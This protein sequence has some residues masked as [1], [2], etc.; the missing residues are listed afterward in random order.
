MQCGLRKSLLATNSPSVEI[1]LSAN[2]F[3]ERGDYRREVAHSERDAVLPCSKAA[4]KVNEMK[5]TKL[6]LGFS[7]LC[8]TASMSFTQTIITVAGNGAAGYSGDGGLATV[9]KLFGPTGVAVDLAGNIYIADFTNNCVRKVSIGTRF[10]TTFAGM[11][12]SM[13]AYGGDTLPAT[14]ANLNQPFNLALDFSG[15]NL[16]IT[17]PGNH[18]VRKVNLNTNIISTAAGT[19]SMCA[20]VSACGDGGKATLAQLDAPHGLAVDKADNLYIGDQGNHCIRKVNTSGVISTIAGDRYHYIGVTGNVNEGDGGQAHSSFLGSPD[21]LALDG[22]G[23]LYIADNGDQVIRKITVCSNQVDGTC[24]ISRI[25][26]SYGI[27]GFSG[28]GGPATSAKLNIPSG[29][30]MDF[31][32]NKLYVSD[33]DNRRVRVIDGGGVIDAFAG[34]GLPGYTGDNGPATLARL[35]DTW[36]LAVDGCGNV[37]IADS[38]ANVIRKVLKGAAPTL[39]PSITTAAPLCSGSNISATGHYAGSTT[40]DSYSWQLQSCTPS[41]I[42]TSAY[43]SGVLTYSGVPST[44]PFVFPNTATVSCNQNYLITFTVK[45]DCPVPTVAKVTKQILINCKPTPIITGNTT[46]CF[47]KPTTLCANYPNN[48][49]YTVEWIYHVGTIVTDVDAQCITVSPKANTIYNLS[50][51]DN[52]TG[53]KSSISVP[54]T[55]VKSNPDFTYQSNY[56]SP[57]NYFT[58]SATP[59]T[60][61]TNGVA[62]FGDLWIVEQIDALGNTIP[63]TK[64]STG[65]SSNPQCWWIYPAA[66]TFNGFDGTKSSGVNNV[67]CSTPSPGKFANGGTYRITHGIWNNFCSWTQT[68]HTVTITGHRIADNYTR[69]ECGSGS[70]VPDHSYYLR[71]SSEYSLIKC[72]MN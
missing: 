60:P 6:V 71:P 68:S 1:R 39:N 10:I 52:V 32:S 54:V 48:S 20:G 50:V 3:Q 55:V 42:P 7:L 57:N 12:G 45:K 69:E 14:Q 43:D 41:G 65:T 67:T 27:N 46:V 23:N 26:G 19:G 40:P 38:T 72:L 58:V 22:G 18:V 56:T 34:T 70:S 30:G 16:Y 24:T 8:L 11:C 36:Q 53:C 29:L 28:D 15:R 33:K 21:A 17:E 13:G 35:A 9:A 66:N 37:Y 62:G 51:T 63:G 2:P 5:T 47:G 25:A 61:Y 64:T 44:A 59:V 49:Q 4:K 31:V